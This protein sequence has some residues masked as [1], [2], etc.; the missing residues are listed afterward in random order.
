MTLDVS[1]ATGPVPCFRGDALVRAIETGVHS[2]ECVDP[3]AVNA[4]GGATEK[5]TKAAAAVVPE[6]WTTYEAEMSAATWDRRHIREISLACTVAE[7]GPPCTMFE[8][9]IEERSPR[10]EPFEAYIGALCSV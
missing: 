5:V 10:W 7:D 2:F 4:E 3:E 8:S 9:S 1:W 6:V